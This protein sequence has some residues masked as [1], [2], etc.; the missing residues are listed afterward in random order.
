MGCD[1]ALFSGWFPRI[2]RHIPR[3]WNPQN[4]AGYIQLFPNS[5]VLSNYYI[6]GNILI[7]FLIVVNL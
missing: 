1:A 6:S 5:I 3:D 7:W 2:Q 4:G